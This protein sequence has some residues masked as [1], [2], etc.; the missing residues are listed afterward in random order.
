MKHRAYFVNLIKLS[1]LRNKAVQSQKTVLQQWKDNV[2]Y[3]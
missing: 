1:Y 3:R 2:S